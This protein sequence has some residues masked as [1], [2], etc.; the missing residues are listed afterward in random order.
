M[1][2]EVDERDS[3]ADTSAGEQRPEADQSGREQIIDEVEKPEEDEETYS[4]LV[5]M[6]FKKDTVESV[7]SLKAATGVQNRTQITVDAITLAK[8]YVDRTRE[9]AEIY[10][11]YPDG[12][13]ETIAMPRFDSR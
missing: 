1:S 4:Q 10:A 13:R 7:K 12:S 8:W 5:S 2:G 6:R 11:E 9:G 3:S